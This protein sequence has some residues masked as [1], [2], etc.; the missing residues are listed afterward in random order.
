M[1][2][3]SYFTNTSSIAEVKYNSDFVDC[4]LF[5]DTGFSYMYKI[6]CFTLASVKPGSQYDV[7]RRKAC[8]CV[9]KNKIY[10]TYKSMVAQF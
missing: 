2:S 10:G 6:R 8:V 1:V 7:R 3:F 5:Y 9:Y 4:I